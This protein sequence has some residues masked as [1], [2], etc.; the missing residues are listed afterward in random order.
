MYLGLGANLGDKR[1]TFTRVLRRLSD[2]LRIDAVSSVYATEPV[3]YADQPE[4]WNMAIRGTTT[5]AP[6]D[7]L[8]EVK[9]I[10]REAGR[11]PTF[12]NGPR[13]I[14]IDILIYGT[15]V[16]DSPPLVIPH[17]RMMQRAFVLRPLVEL[18]SELVHPISGE[19]LA[20]ALEH[21]SFE[22]I[23]RLFDGTELLEQT[24]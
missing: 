5:L 22:R 12:P 3:G 21:G 6:A 13:V 16:I 15:E 14:D 7:L 4:F 2:V 11:A 20:S 8:R 17:P 18:D 23:T 1:A 9:Q 19:R 24:E 10:E